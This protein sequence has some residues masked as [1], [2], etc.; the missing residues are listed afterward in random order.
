MLLV[1][2]IHVAVL[3]CDVWWLEGCFE[4]HVQ[5]E[6]IV[7]GGVEVNG[8]LVETSMEGGD[9]RVGSG[10]FNRWLQLIWRPPKNPVVIRKCSGIPPLQCFSIK[11]VVAFGC[12]LDFAILRKRLREG[13]F[14]LG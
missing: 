14:E 11:M 9:E 2:I 12:P 7:K 4:K 13:D 6:C 10:L 3:S 5:L 8:Q 1:L